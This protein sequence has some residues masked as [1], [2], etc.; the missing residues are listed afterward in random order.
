MLPILPSP[1]HVAMMPVRHH[2]GCVFQRIWGCGIH[3]RKPAVCRDFDPT[4]C[5]WYEPDP[6]KLNGSVVLGVS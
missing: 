4:D 2:G 3:D 1:G 6:D 5:L